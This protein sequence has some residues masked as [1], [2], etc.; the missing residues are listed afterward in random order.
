MVIVGMIDLTIALAIGKAELMGGEVAVSFS[1]NFWKKELIRFFIC[2][3]VNDGSQV[4][5]LSNYFFHAIK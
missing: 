1:K 4:F 2:W 5:S 3:T